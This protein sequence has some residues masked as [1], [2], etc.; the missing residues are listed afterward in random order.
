MTSGKP[1]LYG[2]GKKEIG[3][4]GFVKICCV[5]GMPIVSDFILR[6]L[7]EPREKYQHQR[8]QFC[9]PFQEGYL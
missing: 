7:P 3:N 8:V 4:L 1:V 2:R 6:H 5:I 9:I